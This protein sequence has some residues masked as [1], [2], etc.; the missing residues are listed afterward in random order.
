VNP[1]AVEPDAVECA[2]QQ[3]P[4]AAGV[5]AAAPLPLVVTT[6][7]ARVLLANRAMQRLLGVPVVDVSGRFLAEFAGPPHGRLRRLAAVAASAAHPVTTGSQTIEGV[8]VSRDGRW[9]VFD[10]DRDGNPDIYK[11]AT[12]GGEPIRLTTDSAGDSQPLERNADLRDAM[13]THT[14][15]VE[16]EV[17]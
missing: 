7:D 14:L 5:L 2:G 16:V 3:A 9:L 10:S 13:I 1:D 17:R 11:M 6:P 8:D 12:G 4:D 15:P